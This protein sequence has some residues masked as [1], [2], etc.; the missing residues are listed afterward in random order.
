MNDRRFTEL[1]N[2]RLDHEISP[3]EAAELDA[4][5][6]RDPGR[7]RQY[8]EYG[9]MQQA[10]AQLFE[11]E[12]ARAPA[13]LALER[14]LREAERKV[15]APVSGPLFDRPLVTAFAGFAAM[16]ACVA[17]VVLRSS[18]GLTVATPAVQPVVA[19]NQ[20]PLKV[21]AML[22]TYVIPASTPAPYANPPAPY[23]TVPLGVESTPNLAATDPS[24]EVA[25]WVHGVELPALKP[26]NLDDLSVESTPPVQPS[27][28]GESSSSSLQVNSDY[29]GF[30][31]QR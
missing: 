1:L 7:R 27:F 18:P 23:K 21:P 30:Q 3:G 8:V 31:F 20:T 5:I 9:R 22:A 15:A 11:R 10:C 14:A 17:F 26:V 6:Q 13:S 29:V 19:S 2:L 28:A 4:E 12:H 25:D 16:A 24:R